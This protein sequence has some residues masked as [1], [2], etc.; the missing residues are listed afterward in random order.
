[1]AMHVVLGDG[2]MTRKEL[3]ETL[4]DLWDKAGDEA[5]W[6]VLLGKSEPSDTDQ[7]L[8][9]WL[10][11]NEIY[12]EIVTDDADSV[13]DVYSQAQ[14][15]HTAKRLAQ[16][17]GNLLQTKPED[18]EDALILALFVSEDPSAEEDRWLNTII[19]SAMD[20]GFRALALND[21]LV[22]VQVDGGA[23]AKEEEAVAETPKK[24]PAKKAAARPAEPEPETEQMTLPGTGGYTREQLEDLD[25]GALKE[26]AAGMGIE[27][28]PRT[29][30]NTY[31]DHILGEVKGEAPAVEV[32]EPPVTKVIEHEVPL[33]GSS[34][35]NGDLPP[36]DEIVEQV[37]DRLAKLLQER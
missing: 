22:E 36:V 6:F 28:P 20:E 17:I 26:I 23:P 30:M 11:K 29:R 21:G 24:T 35:T 3:T 4:K 33:S 14:E 16:K 10:H 32:T 31:I 5:F 9:S 34:G 25:M 2:E 1:V 12:Y 7:A 37:L 18:D 15:T 13:S 8:V 27:L 19:R